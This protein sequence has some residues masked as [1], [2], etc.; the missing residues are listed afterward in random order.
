MPSGYENMKKK[1]EQNTNTHQGHRGNQQK[2]RS[3]EC[4]WVFLLLNK[5]DG[6]QAIAH[7]TL[8]ANMIA[9]TIS[10]FWEF[11]FII[12]K[13][14]YIKDDY[15]MQLIL[16]QYFLDELVKDIIN[17]EQNKARQTTETRD[18]ET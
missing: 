9:P 11:I 16:V 1:N 17:R 4:W 8:I 14:C 12:K 15:I 13:K 18:S 6:E 5:I 3:T 7:K 2:S 10:R